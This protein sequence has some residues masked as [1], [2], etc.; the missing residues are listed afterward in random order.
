MEV[1]MDSNGVL[2]LVDRLEGLLTEDAVIMIQ[3]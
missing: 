2:N 1:P 3:S